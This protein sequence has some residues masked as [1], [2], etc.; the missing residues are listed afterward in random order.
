MVDGCCTDRATD[1]LMETAGFENVEQKRYD[2][3]IHEDAS[4]TFKV[5]GTVIKPHVMGVA[6]K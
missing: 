5:C 4:I 3:P 1:K 2:L 6:T